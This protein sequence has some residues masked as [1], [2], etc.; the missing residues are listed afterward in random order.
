[1][2]LSKFIRVYINDFNLN[3]SSGRRGPFN[4]YAGNYNFIKQ[5]FKYTEHILGNTK[6]VIFPL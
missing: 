3:Y 5:D 1:M 4:Y 6:V 2:S